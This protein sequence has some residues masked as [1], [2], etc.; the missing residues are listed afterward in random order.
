MKIQAECSVNE[1][2]CHIPES[3]EVFKQLGIDTC[4][5]GSL[6]LADAAR[7]AGLSPDILLAKIERAAVAAS[8]SP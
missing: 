8:N 1:F 7:K 6:T 5:G 3:L 2:V 4:C